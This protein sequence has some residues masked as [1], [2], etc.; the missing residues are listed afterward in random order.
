MK[1]FFIAFSLL[2][3]SVGFALSP[4][5]AFEIQQENAAFDQLLCFFGIPP[6]AEP[7]ELVA[8]T[9]RLWYQSGKERWELDAR[10]EELRPQLWPLFEKMGLFQ[11]LKP[12]KNHYDYA[13][14]NGALLSSV[15]KRVAYLSSLC[16]QGIRFGQIVFLAGERPL[17]AFEKEQT[18]P[19]LSTEREMVE[20]VYRNSSLPKDLPVQFV[21]AP[22]RQKADG[23][24]TRPHRSDTILAW[25][26]QNPKKGSCLAISNQPHAAYEQAAARRALPPSFQLETVGPAL[27]GSPSVALILETIAKQ[28]YSTYSTH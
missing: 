14:V 26:T 13:L 11:A 28:I 23:T 16:E 12:S 7:E 1:S 2:S 24:W 10:Y 19:L 17:Q 8:E 6:N 5:H 3:Q 22:M 20:W 15:E 21:D 4:P 18:S 9:Q 27:T 25:L